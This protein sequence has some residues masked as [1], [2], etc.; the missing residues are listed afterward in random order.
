[1]VTDRNDLTLHA[2]LCQNTIKHGLGAWAVGTSLRSKFFNNYALGK[3]IVVSIAAAVATASVVAASVVATIAAA[4]T[5][6]SVV[7]TIVAAVVA[8]G[9]VITVK[10]AAGIF[11][12]SFDVT[13]FNDTLGRCATIVGRDKGNDL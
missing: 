5:A 10:T 4:V 11:R 3:V 12:R 13:I 9:I 2:R 7:A 1:M 6:A 8:A